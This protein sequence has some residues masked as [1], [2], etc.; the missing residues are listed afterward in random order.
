VTVLVE[1]PCQETELLL[2]GRHAG[3]APEVDGRVLLRDGF[4]RPGEFVSV[5]VERAYAADLVGRIVG[6]AAFET[7]VREVTRPGAVGS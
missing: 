2:E 5:L 6:S 7:A 4:A 1:G 3:M